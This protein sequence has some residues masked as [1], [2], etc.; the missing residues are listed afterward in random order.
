MDAAVAQHHIPYV[1][2]YTNVSNREEIGVKQ[3][4]CGRTHTHTSTYT[5]TN[6]YTYIYKHTYT[7]TYA[8]KHIYIHIVY[9]YIIHIH[10]YTYTGIENRRETRAPES[11][12]HLVK[13]V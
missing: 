9:T 12:R 5:H 3:G 8:N 1:H 6:T 7:Y 10:T 11:L 13:G 4:S 2:N